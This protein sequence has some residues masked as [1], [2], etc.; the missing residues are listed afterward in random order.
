MPAT[1]RK[2][3]LMHHLVLHLVRT[4][5]YWRELSLL[6]WLSLV[7]PPRRRRSATGEHGDDGPAPLREPDGKPDAPV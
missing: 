3:R 1:S 5:R 4:A 7:Y 2:A 6:C